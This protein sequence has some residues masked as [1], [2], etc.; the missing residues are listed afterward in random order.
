MRL[1]YRLDDGLHYPALWYYDHLSTVEL[2]AR[3]TCEYFIKER[4]TYT[5]TATRKEKNMTVI[6]LEEELDDVEGIERIYSHIGFEVKEV[7]NKG[8]YHTIDE[9]DLHSHDEALELFHCDVILL[10]EREFHLDSRE[11]D[12][13]R[14]CYVYY[15][16]F[17]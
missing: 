1:E 10:G 8:R 11:L 2:V 17:R 5:I 4:K 12:E 3:M 16:S 9:R 14:K 15:G 13:D 6:Y 7:Q